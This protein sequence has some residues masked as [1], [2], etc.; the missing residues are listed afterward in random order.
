MGYALN[1]LQKPKSTGISSGGYG[2]NVNQIGSTLPTATIYGEAKVG[3]VNF[4]QEV[5]DTDMLYQGIAMA[6][7]EIEGFQKIFMNDEEITSTSAGFNS[8]YLQVD[9]TLQLNGETREVNGYSQYATRLGTLDQEYVPILNSA[10]DWGPS[11][12]A[13][14]V[15]YLFFRHEYS[16]SY[17]PNGVPVISAIVRGKKVYDPRTS[18]TAWSDNPA[19][20]LRDYLLSS[21]IADA[22]EIDED[23]FTTAANICD[24]IVPLAAGGSQKRYT[25]NGSFT[26]D[27]SATTII[28]SILATMG[29]MIWYTNG[30]CIIHILNP[31]LR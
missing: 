17:F 5:V 22:D 29:G 13:S 28:N 14:G 23:L 31:N 16:R 21:S 9:T 3:G 24:E 20:C 15:A 1:A 8:N 10:N 2:I 19:I 30:K 12:R 11:N 4:Y 25:C 6:D 7:H 26:S 18:T 27:E